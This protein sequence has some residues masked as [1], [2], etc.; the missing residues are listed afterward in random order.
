MFAGR[1]TEKVINNQA[2]AY[3]EFKRLFVQYKQIQIYG[4]N[5]YIMFK[6]L[7]KVKS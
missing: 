3:P 4:F 5:V 6:H 7:Q 2:L 1:S